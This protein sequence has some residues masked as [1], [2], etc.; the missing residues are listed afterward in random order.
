M[1]LIHGNKKIRFDV[2][3]PHG[4]RPHFHLEKQTTTGKWTNAASEHRY[5]FK[6]E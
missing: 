1:I 4:D 5:Y 3:D 2:K 6:E